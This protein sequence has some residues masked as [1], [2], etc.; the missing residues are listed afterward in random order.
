MEN[1]LGWKMHSRWGG[2]NQQ[3][4]QKEKSEPEMGRPEEKSVWGSGVEQP[5]TI[6]LGVSIG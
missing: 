1:G 4:L 6:S 2:N 3:R 5:R